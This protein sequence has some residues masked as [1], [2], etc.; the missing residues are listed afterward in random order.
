MKKSA[1]ESGID[2]TIGRS[3]ECHIQSKFRRRL[4][5]RQRRDMRHGKRIEKAASNKNYKSYN[6]FS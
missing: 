3:K 4:I 5:G 1:E 2:V 6:F